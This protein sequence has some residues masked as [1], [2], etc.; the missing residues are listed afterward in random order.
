MAIKNNNSNDTNLSLFLKRYWIYLMPVLLLIIVFAFFKNS[1][2]DFFS[3]QDKS[4]KS[5]SVYGSTISDLEA[6]EYA[7]R[8]YTY[9]A[10]FFGTNEAGIFDVFKHLY[11]KGDFAKVYNNFGLKPYD[12]LFGL[13]AYNESWGENL[14][15]LSWLSYE[16]SSSDFEKLKKISGGFP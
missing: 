7:E 6:K 14:D 11:S 8:L 2:L 3:P 5:L 16:L 12:D 4:F 9:M 13:S 15:L 1:V 10:Q